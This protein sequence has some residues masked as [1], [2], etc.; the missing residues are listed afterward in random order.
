[1]K[2]K[3]RQIDWYRTPV[4]REALAKFNA[5]SDLLGGLQTFGY[6]GLLFISGGFA[7]YAATNH[8][9]YVLLPALFLH[10]TFYA[11]MVNGFHELIHRTVFRTQPLN[12]IF[13]WIFSFSGWYDPVMFWASHK[14][15]HKYTLHPPD[16]LEV[17]LPTKITFRSFLK[18]AI[19]NP[20]AFL[21]RLRNVYRLSIGRL[22]GEWVN[23]LFPPDALQERQRLMWWSRCLLAG[24]VLLTAVSIWA[25]YWMLPVL[26]TFAPFYGG[27]LFFLCNNTQHAGLQDNVDDFRYCTR[28]IHLNPFVQFLYW[29]MNFHIEHHMYAA[30]PCYRLHALHRHIAFDLPNSPDGLLQAWREI[31]GILQQQKKD[32]AYIF[33]PTVPDA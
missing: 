19:I 24:H 33:V 13:L 26:I 21:D 11:F 30:V 17:T 5:R 22:E 29:H 31:T 18:T 10:G 8:S 15:H 25:G 12:Q 14:A 23:S 16:D 27:W 6:V 9:L 7:W 4:A 1:M 20:W 2:K 3:S 28:T 32:P